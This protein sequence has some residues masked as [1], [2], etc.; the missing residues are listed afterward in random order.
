MKKDSRVVAGLLLATCIA[1]A[2]IAPAF[3]WKRQVNFGCAKKNRQI[4]ATAFYYDRGPAHW[5]MGYIRYSY[6][7]SGGGKADTHFYVYNGYGA[8]AWD[9]HTPD[10]RKNKRYRTK[11]RHDGG[12]LVDIRRGQKARIKQKTAFDTFGRDPKCSY[13]GYL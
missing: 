9:W 13:A 7:N 2:G 12:E 1:V 6:A 4:S 11:I 3:A 8:A 10:N 5:R